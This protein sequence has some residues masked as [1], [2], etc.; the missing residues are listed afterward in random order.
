MYQ[1]PTLE[2][3]GSVEALTE[4]TDDSYG[5]WHKGKGHGGHGGHGHKGGWG[6][7]FGW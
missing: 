2:T 5:G 3:Y 1:K 6:G 7:G 4:H